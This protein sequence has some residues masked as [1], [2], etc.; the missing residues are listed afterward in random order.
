MSD[1][2]NRFVRSQ[3]GH[4]ANELHNH[5]G[6]DDAREDKTEREDLEEEIEALDAAES[7]VEVKV[8]KK[9]DVFD[10][11]VELP[12]DPADIE[13]EVDPEDPIEEKKIAEAKKE[14]EAKAEEAIEEAI[15]ED[16]EAEAE[17]E[18]EPIN[19]WKKKEENQAYM[20]IDEVKEPKAKTG[21]GW[22]VATILFAL[23]AI[24]GCGAAAYL[25]LFDGTT[26]FLGREVTSKVEGAKAPTAPSAPETPD[27]TPIAEAFDFDAKTI[28]YAGFD[29]L[30]TKKN[31]QSATPIKIDITEDGK[32][33]YII[34]DVTDGVGGYAG[35]WYR[36]T[37]K[38]AEWT[39]LQAGH[40]FPACD[41][42]T[43]E[44]HKFMLDYGY[45]DDELNSQYIGCYEK[46]VAN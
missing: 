24:A 22:K 12:V 20:Q 32:Y 5:G 2:E 4:S 45:I 13:P 25:F 14:E 18:A 39:V 19:D 41:S 3:G 29:K 1:E 43:K 17:P 6:H 42:V 10:D 35:V 11:D 44:Q 15:E 33:Y 21:A 46:T 30:F 27:T 40:S 26:K 38:G 31:D 37:T 28:D 36:E 7:R 34:A 23:L 16:A 9:I 8:G